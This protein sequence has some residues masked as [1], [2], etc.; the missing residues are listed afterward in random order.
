MKKILV[1]GGSSYVG[2]SLIAKMDLCSIIFTYNKTKVVGGI[3][4]DSTVDSIEE[5]VDLHKVS[6]VVILL[7][8]TNP[9][10]C[11]EDVEKSENLN[12]HS[13]KRIVNILSLYDIDVIFASSEFVY[14]GEKGNYIELDCAN[15]ILLYGKQKLEIEKYIKKNIA[16]YTILR[17]A[18]IYG[19]QLSD[20]TLFTSWIKLIE[21]NSSIVCA[22]DQYFSPVHI[23]NVIDAI[24]FA[25]NN[26]MQGVFNLSGPVRRSRMELLQILICEI[27]KVKACNISTIPCSIDDF[28]LKERRPKDVSMNPSKLV[29]FTGINL[30]YPDEVCAKIVNKFYKN[31]TS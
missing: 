9:D 22:D 12:V 23:N 14:D 20:K 2:R 7:G 30:L 29:S 28:N 16:K 25:I 8:D 13:V 10:T 5:I 24:L 19:D 6:S 26:K 15:P 27:N 31:T 3:K 11:V 17:F 18:K 1:L 21:D 4:F